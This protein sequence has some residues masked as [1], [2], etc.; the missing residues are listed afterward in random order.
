VRANI[1]TRKSITLSVG[2]PL[3]PYGFAYRRVYGS[4]SITLSVGTPL[5][6]YGIAY[7]RVCGLSPSV[8]FKKSFQVG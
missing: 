7:R 6:P 2:T 4:K 3:C 5:C 8:L 1:V